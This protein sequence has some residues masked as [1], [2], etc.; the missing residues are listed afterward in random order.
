M[1]AGTYVE[2]RQQGVP[3]CLDA[4]Q[5]RV[6]ARRLLVG[7][8]VERI[9]HVCPGVVGEGGAVLLE[10]GAIHFLH[11]ELDGRAQRR[12]QVREARDG[13]LCGVARPVVVLVGAKVRLEERRLREVR[14][15]ARHVLGGHVERV[16][17]HGHRGAQLARGGGAPRAF[18]EAAHV[19]GAAAAVHAQQKDLEVVVLEQGEGGGHGL[20]GDVRVGRGQR[21][22]QH[23]AQR[24][25]HVVRDGA[26]VR[27]R[28]GVR[29]IE[30]V[31]LLDTRA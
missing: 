11:L 28:G 25:K 12:R 13:R 18:H 14:L 26:R 15:H 17:V 31:H 1:S 24:E 27:P 19:E 29:G 6:V 7:G 30:G 23:V 8:V 3:A 2:R 16:Q 5:H 21:A 9:L 22:R 4:V 20:V 10:Q